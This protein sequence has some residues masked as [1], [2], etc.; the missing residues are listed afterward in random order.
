MDLRVRTKSLH[1][2]VIEFDPDDHLVLYY[3]FFSLAQQ[4]L[5]HRHRMLGEVPHRANR[6]TN[7]STSPMRP[8]HEMMRMKCLDHQFL[9][10]FHL[11]YFLN[12]SGSTLESCFDAFS[13][14]FES[15][16]RFSYS[17]CRSCCDA[18]SL[19]I[20]PPKRKRKVLVVLSLLPTTRRSLVP[21][22]I[23]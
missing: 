4:L 23:P 1:C 22:S 9:I 11:S 19:L 3:R 7:A 8:R 12:W 20:V 18:L 14:S 17:R 2:L 16:P 13:A 15:M 6:A 5:V 10:E 21:S